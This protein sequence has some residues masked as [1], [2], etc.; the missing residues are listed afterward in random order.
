VRSLFRS[1]TEQPTP[2]SAVV[3]P[4]EFPPIPL[5]L[6][7]VK[8]E[9][10]S[11]SAEGFVL[12]GGNGG[13]IVLE[14]VVTSSLPCFEFNIPDMVYVPFPDPTLQRI[15][16]KTHGNI[17]NANPLDRGSYLIMTT[18]TDLIEYYEGKYTKLL[19]IPYNMNPVQYYNFSRYMWSFSFS[20]MLCLEH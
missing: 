20:R 14:S 8:W 1:L 17:I 10:A 12:A 3:V 11:G 9:R 13:T 6:H 4:S 7:D 18:D 19:Y 2:F 16:I 5:A 15:S